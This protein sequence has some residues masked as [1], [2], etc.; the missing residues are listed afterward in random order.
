VVAFIEVLLE[1]AKICGRDMVKEK[2]L[3]S[4]PEGGLDDRRY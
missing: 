2:D 3:Q 4:N 1:E